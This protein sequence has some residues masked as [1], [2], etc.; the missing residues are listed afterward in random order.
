MRW[1]FARTAAGAGTDKP[2]NVDAHG[3]TDAIADSVTDCDAHRTSDS[4]AD[5]K[6]DADRDADVNAGR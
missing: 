6:P 5:C 4:D 3:Q 1:R 2:P